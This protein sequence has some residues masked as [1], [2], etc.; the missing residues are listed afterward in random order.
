MD[1]KSFWDRGGD[2]LSWLVND[3]YENVK[4]KFSMFTPGAVNHAKV[5]AKA[6]DAL[7]ASMVAAA[8]AG[9]DKTG[10]LL[11]C[12]VWADDKGVCRVR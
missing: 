10:Y 1:K 3:S 6:S 11:A 9:A 12:F 5:Y 2:A 7:T 4:R 8:G